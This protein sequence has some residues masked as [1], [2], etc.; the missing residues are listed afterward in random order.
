MIGIT[1]NKENCCSN[2]LSLLTNFLNDIL[3]VSQFIDE[4]KNKDINGVVIYMV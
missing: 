2:M 3:K 4:E 1:D